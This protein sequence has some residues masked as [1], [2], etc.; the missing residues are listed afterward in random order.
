MQAKFFFTKLFSVSE[1]MLFPHDIAGSDY[2]YIQPCNRDPSCSSGRRWKA[3]LPDMTTSPA[4]D[5][6][7]SVKPILHT[8]ARNKVD[9]PRKHKNAPPRSPFPLPPTQP[10][11][12]TSVPI[13]KSLASCLAD[14]PPRLSVA[15]SKRPMLP[16]GPKGSTGTGTRNTP[17]PLPQRKPGNSDSVS[18]TPHSPA[19][20]GAAN[21]SCEN[22]PLQV[23][24]VSAA[25]A[26]RSNDFKS[27]RDVPSD[28]RALTP[29]QLAKCMRMLKIP[30]PC[31]CAF[32][33]KD[34]D[35]EILMSIDQSILIDEFQ[36]GRFD[37]VKLMKFAK[38]GY[39]PNVG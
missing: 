34:V 14:G 11:I 4:Y 24:P 9:V 38:D 35:G 1:I 28:T 39:R 29:E 7:G 27:I 17:R 22:S 10:V 3:D 25:N 13:Q 33:E 20:L 37:A 12:E 19:F 23:K 8:R 30:E 18:T 15:P 5:R 26:T 2:E 31:I 6:Q 32:R 21:A 36:F 16:V